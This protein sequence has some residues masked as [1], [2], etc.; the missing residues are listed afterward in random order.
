MKHAQTITQYNLDANKLF[1]KLQ[2][3]FGM[4]Q[5]DRTLFPDK[6]IEVANYVC[7]DD[8]DVLV[9]QEK[10]CGDATLRQ[11]ATMTDGRL[12]HTGVNA[13]LHKIFNS[14]YRSDILRHFYK[15]KNDSYDFFN[16][17]VVNS[18]IVETYPRA[19]PQFKKLLKINQMYRMQKLEEF[20]YH[21]KE[22]RQVIEELKDRYPEY[23]SAFK[24]VEWTLGKVMG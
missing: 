12:S 2:L 3:H 17:S 7:E 15:D 1:K 16:D 10:I 18:V 11:V 5:D 13:K 6:L 23:A 19:I 24:G 4:E 21:F 14:L 20:N 9:L 22:N 8:L